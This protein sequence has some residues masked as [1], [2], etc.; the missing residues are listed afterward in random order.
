M[1]N[2]GIAVVGFSLLVMLAGC[3][4]QTVAP[5][6]PVPKAISKV[7]AK[8]ELKPEPAKVEFD[9][10]N[11]ELP[12]EVKYEGGFAQLSFPQ[13]VVLSRER[14]LHLFLYFQ[15]KYCGPCKE[16][17]R[18]VFPS[19]EFQTFARS[20]VSIDV[21]G[22]S[23]DGE[24]VAKRYDV[25]SYPTMIVCE[26]GGEE[27][28][29]FF[30]F[31]DTGEFVNK[32]KDYMEHRHTA[33][34]YKE[35]A[36]ATPDDLGLQFTAGR[37]LAVRK[38]G[39]E[40]IP[41]LE[42]VIEKG[43]V[44][45]VPGQKVGVV[46]RATLLLARTVYLDQLKARDKALPLLEQLAVRYPDSY[47]GE[48]A[49]YMMARIYIE[50]KEIDKARE[51]LLQRLNISG[52]QAIQYFRFGSFCLRYR[53]F[54]A[55]AIEMLRKGVEKHPSAAYLWKTLSDL[56]FQ[57]RALDEAVDAMVKAV[58]A[59]PKSQAYQRLLETYTRARDKTK[60]KK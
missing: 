6:G 39:E 4:S 40:A 22:R 28:E 48:E 31:R 60:E 23:P 54:T 49:V 20:I 34:H 1:K 35:L 36:E 3:P 59:D 13:G 58:E 10:E 17:D 46:P 50:T 24:L 33:S 38:R 26:P 37:E 43:P 2:R 57:D 12:E 55:E 11:V 44:A 29:R 18:K 9:F 30:G 19:S 45:K 47:H 7:V 21:D 56:Y 15:T 14:G 5:A 41:F 8:P 53:V 16:L 25:S 42:R 27:I 32:I 52:E 51:V